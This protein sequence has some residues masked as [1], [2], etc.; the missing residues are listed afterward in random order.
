MGAPSPATRVRASRARARHTMNR[1][2]YYINCTKEFVAA[3]RVYRPGKSRRN[4][5]SRVRRLVNRVFSTIYNIERVCGGGGGCGRVQAGRR[6]S[7]PGRYTY[8]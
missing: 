7:L 2:D 6:Q 1:H 8:I 3:A 5:R 4:F